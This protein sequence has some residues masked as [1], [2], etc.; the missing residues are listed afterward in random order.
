MASSIVEKQTPDAAI[1]SEDRKRKNY[2]E[3]WGVLPTNEPY[4]VILSVVRDKLYHT[5]CAPLP[6]IR[7][8]GRLANVL[9]TALLYAQFA[10]LPRK[11]LQLKFGACDRREVLHHCMVHPHVNVKVYLEND[12]EAYTSKVLALVD[13]S[14]FE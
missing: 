12:S 11:Q 8:F 2:T 6:S 14:R 7:L 1:I 10:S 3:F 13:S 5:R 9:R 4:R